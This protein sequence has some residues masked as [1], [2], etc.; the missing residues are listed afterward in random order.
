MHNIL[1]IN[2]LDMSTLSRAKRCS[3]SRIFDHLC[4]TLL[5]REFHCHPPLTL[6]VN[7]WSTFAIL[8]TGLTLRL[9]KR[10]GRTRT[11]HQKP[12]V[13]GNKSPASSW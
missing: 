1:K 12:G 4:H 11:I 2:Y 5:F 13:Q 9:P 8:A 10:D 3:A 6:R 7:C